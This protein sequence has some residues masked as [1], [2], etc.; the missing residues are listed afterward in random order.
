MSISL[1]QLQQC[2]IH[3]NVCKTTVPILPVVLNCGHSLCQPCWTKQPLK[4][5]PVCKTPITLTKPNHMLR[6]LLLSVTGYDTLVKQAM[7]EDS[8]QSSLDNMEATWGKVT[9][10]QTTY[11]V[12]V[13]KEL[14]TRLNKL[15]PGV[16]C[17][18]LAL[19]LNHLNPPTIFQIEKGDYN[20]KEQRYYICFTAEKDVTTK[21]YLIIS[22]K[23]I[24]Y[25]TK[26]GKK[27]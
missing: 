13:Q 1:Q 15:G 23:D 12:D 2:G 4:K 19:A 9:I 20:M 10:Q 27:F 21:T 3:C 26:V 25:E 17:K 11:P 7:Y 8:I 24:P 16:N 5:C 18:E 6:K 14:M 22:D